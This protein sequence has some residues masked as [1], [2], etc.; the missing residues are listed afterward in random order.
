MHQNN[1]RGHSI[2]E[3]ECRPKMEKYI[4]YYLT[5]GESWLSW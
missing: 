2:S 1:T 4:D 5:G 3:L